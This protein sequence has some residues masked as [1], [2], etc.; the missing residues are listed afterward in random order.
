MNIPEK[1]RVLYRTY[2][3]SEVD[4]LHDGGDDLYGQVQYLEERI[5]LNS[6]ASDETKKAALIHE[7]VHTIDDLF[8]IGLEEKQVEQL[9]VGIYNLIRDNPEMFISER[10][11]NE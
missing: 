10:R 1:I 11:P 2:Q 6:A 9:G 3:I 7:V 8:G 4:N 5:L